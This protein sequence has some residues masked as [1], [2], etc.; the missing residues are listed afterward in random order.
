MHA[1]PLNDDVMEYCPGYWFILDCNSTGFLFPD[2]N[3]GLGT[4]CRLING[5]A[6]WSYLGSCYPGNYLNVNIETY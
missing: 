4:E 5:V 3:P 2:G 1:R 6:K